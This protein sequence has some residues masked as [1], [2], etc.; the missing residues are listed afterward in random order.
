[1]TCISD[2]A[3]KDL[4]EFYNAVDIS[5]QNEQEIMETDA[6]SMRSI[7]LAGPNKSKKAK[8]SEKSREIPALEGAVDNLPS[9][10][11]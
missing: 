9:Y 1:M 6:G 3:D 7:L 11:N 5:L 2:E 8:K 10:K 4:Q